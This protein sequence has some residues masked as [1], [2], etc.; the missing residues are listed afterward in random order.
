MS[1]NSGRI[2]IPL[3]VLTLFG[4]ACTKT[5]TSNQTGK[6]TNTAVSTAPNPSATYITANPVD[7]SQIEKISKFRS[8]A[9]HDFS[10][11]NF[12]GETETDR[13]MKHYLKP[14]SA[15]DDNKAALYA[16]FDGQVYEAEGPQPEIQTS[17]DNWVFL[18]H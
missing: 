14:L 16:P 5:N 3:V 11:H 18:K 9:G 4:A 7:L 13:S 15:F 1:G 10:G 12:L 2:F 6:V 17:P 8:C